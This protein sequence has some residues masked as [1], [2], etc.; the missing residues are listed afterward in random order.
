MRPWILVLVMVLV[1]GCG[2]KLYTIK[3]NP[4]S[5]SS[6]L[7][8]VIVYQPRLM[9]ATYKFTRLKNSAGQ[10]IGSTPND[11][12]LV[13]YDKVETHPDYST[14]YG[15][16]YKPGPF[17]SY[18]F[19]VNLS[20]GMVTAVNAESKSQVPE[21]IGALTGAVEKLAP[22][23]AAAAPPAPLVPPPA[24]KPA[25]NAVPRLVSLK[26]LQ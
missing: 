3:H 25:C 8:G 13:E 10:I 19:S 9:K 12:E 16:V 15:L 26:P 21:V 7:P 4:N 5:K 22:I 24:G 18:K 20:N 6:V 17:T 11:C 1:P 2:G 14:P 23:L